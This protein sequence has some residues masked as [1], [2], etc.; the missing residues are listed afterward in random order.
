MEQTTSLKKNYKGLLEPTE[1]AAVSPT[2]PSV[3]AGGNRTRDREHGHPTGTQSLK[4][5]EQR[6]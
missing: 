4:T 3:A 2:P 5:A 1:G 6:S